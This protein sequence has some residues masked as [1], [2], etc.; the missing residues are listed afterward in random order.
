MTRG[1]PRRRPSR[2]SGG[3]T[4][5]GIGLT[6]GVPARRSRKSAFACLDQRRIAEEVD[7]RCRHHLRGMLHALVRG[8]RLSLRDELPGMAGRADGI[9]RAAHLDGRDD[10]ADGAHIGRADERPVPALRRED[11]V[12]QRDS[13]RGF[14]PKRA[15]EDAMSS[16]VR[17]SWISA[18]KA[19]SC[20]SKT[21]GPE[22]LEVVDASAARAAC[23]R[24]G[25]RRR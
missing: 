12:A 23:C 16:S 6:N 4:S 5:S 22:P 8:R 20:S 19:L 14:R 24:R 1:R 10:P 9:G 25:W 17:V 15:K 11:R 2:E 21:G 13:V 3:F 18:A 7:G